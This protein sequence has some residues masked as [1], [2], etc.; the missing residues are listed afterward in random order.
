MQ[1]VSP[2]QVRT[3]PKKFYDKV[4]KVKWPGCDTS[5]AFVEPEWHFSYEKYRH[6]WQTWAKNKAADEDKK[7]SSPP[8][9]PGHGVTCGA[10]SG[11]VPV[12]SFIHWVDLIPHSPK[13]LGAVN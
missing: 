6:E 1:P 9:Q 8:L 11:S 2:S 4:N 13:Y 7:G 12:L 3:Y 5:G 10:R